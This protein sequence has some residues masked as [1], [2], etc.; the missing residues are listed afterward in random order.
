MFFTKLTKIPFFFDL[1]LDRDLPIEIFC[2]SE[3]K[4][5]IKDFI[6][7]NNCKFQTIYNNER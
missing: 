4:I 6:Q 5:Y 3:Y 1:K 2:I 7:C